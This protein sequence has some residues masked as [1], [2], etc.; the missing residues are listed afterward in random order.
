MNEASYT[1]WK[2]N[3]RHR[4]LGLGGMEESSEDV[5]RCSLV[6]FGRC[7]VPVTGR[8]SRRRRHQASEQTRSYQSVPDLSDLLGW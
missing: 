2:G 8:I 1:K 7:S 3:R 4:G 6:R 5:M